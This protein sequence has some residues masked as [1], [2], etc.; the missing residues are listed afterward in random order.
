MGIY[1]IYQLAEVVQNYITKIALPRRI[2]YMQ[3]K[4][5]MRKSFFN[6]T[7]MIPDKTKKNKIILNQLIT[8]Q[9]KGYQP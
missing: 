2:V 8:D 3:L 1:A 7:D 4:R 9:A 5:T 6:H